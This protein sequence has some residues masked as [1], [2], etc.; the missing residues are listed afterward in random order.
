MS[1]TI[2]PGSSYSGR[3]LP[4]TETEALLRDRLREH[5]AVLAGDIGERNLWY[6][7]A[8]NYIEDRLTEAGYTPERQDFQSRLPT[9][10][11]R[12]QWNR[13]GDYRS[14]GRVIR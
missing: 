1:L 12:G 6:W 8:A 2:M 10:S 13:Q 9:D 3:L 4:L 11:A 7:D 14:G 5:V